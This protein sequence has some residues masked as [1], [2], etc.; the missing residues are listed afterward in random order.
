[1]W[2]LLLKNPIQEG[3]TIRR[4]FALCQVFEE[5]RS[6]VHCSFNFTFIALKIAQ[7]VDY[8]E[9]F[10]KFN[11]TR[12]ILINTI[13]QVLYLLHCLDKTKSDKGNL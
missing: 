10:V 4:K 1:M 13:Y 6:G 5:L 12:L 8:V 3:L 9:E 7:F 11:L 2:S